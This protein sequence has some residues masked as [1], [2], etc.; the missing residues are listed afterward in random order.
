MVGQNVLNEKQALQADEQFQ[1][2]EKIYHLTNEQNNHMHAQD[3]VIISLQA[4]MNVLNEK[5]DALI[6]QNQKPIRK[7][8]SKTE[9]VA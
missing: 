6:A 8:A 5:M 4:Q 3:S 7:R 1:T 2:T 9:G